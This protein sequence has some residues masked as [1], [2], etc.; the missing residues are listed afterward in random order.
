MQM[1]IQHFHNEAAEA[2]G[3]NDQNEAALM[4]GF[5][6]KWVPIVTNTIEALRNE[7]SF[8]ELELTEAQSALEE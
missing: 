1:D 7:K 4:R 2:L 5:I 8:L 3:A 6:E